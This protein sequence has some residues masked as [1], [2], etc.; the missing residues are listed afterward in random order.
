VEGCGLWFDHHLSEKERLQLEGRFKGR[1]EMVQ[2]AAR[3]IYNYYLFLGKLGRFEEMLRFVDK[4][5]SADLTE[6]EILNPEGWVLLGFI[7][8]PRTGLSHVEGFRVEMVDHIRKKSITDILALDDVKERIE[9]YFEFNNSFRDHL[10]AHS[11]RDGPVVITDS[12]N[13]SDIPPGNR[14]LIYSLFPEA[15]ISI[16]ILNAHEGKD[17]ISVGYSVTNRTSN[18]NV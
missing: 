3:V 12:R 6:D 13:H 5:D 18:V 15:N 16:R 4:V 11:H 8:D 2:S 1:S 17:L 10:L 14:F 7:C 9:K